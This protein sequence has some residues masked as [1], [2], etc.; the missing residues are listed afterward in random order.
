MLHRACRELQ[1]C[2]KHCLGSWVPVK[3]ALSGGMYRHNDSDS[4]LYSNNISSRAVLVAPQYD[5]NP[6]ERPS[7]KKYTGKICESKLLETSRVI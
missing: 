2:E 5:Y 3:R 4:L 6:K 1:E 7:A